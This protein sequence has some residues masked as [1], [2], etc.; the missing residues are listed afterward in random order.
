M[1]SFGQPSAGRAFAPSARQAALTDMQQRAKIEAFRKVGHA[2]LLALTVQVK[3]TCVTLMSLVAQPPSRTSPH[4]S[5]IDTLHTIVSKLPADAFTPSMINYILFPITQILRQSPP[6]SLPENCLE[7]TFRLLSHVVENWKG[8]EVGAWEQ[9]WRFTAAS[10]GISPGGEDV[11]GKG[12]QLGQETL[13][14]AVNLLAALLK[15][16]GD[17]HPSLAMLGLVSTPKSS[18]MPTLFQTITILL[19]TA[20]PSPPH[21]QL[22]LTSLRLLRAL[23]STYLTGQKTVLAAVL[24]GLVSKMAKL[25][26][27]ELKGL[28]GGIAREIAELLA[29]VIVGTL[30]DADLRGL[31]VLR[32]LVEDLGHLAEEW[33]GIAGD[34]LPPEDPPPS[35]APSA[36][37]PFPPLTASY[38][39]FTSSQLQ[40]AIPPIMSS[41]A[42]HNSYEAR[43]GAIALASALITQCSESL[44]LLVPRA[45]STLL[46]LSKDAFDPVRLDARRKLLAIIPDPELYAT[47][48]ELLSTAINSLP[49]LITSQQDE[50]LRETAQLVTALAEISTEVGTRRNPIAALL[51]PDGHVER[52][53]WALLACLEFG[54]PAGWSAADSAAKVAQR[55]WEQRLITS[56]PL[57]EAGDEPFPTMQLRH[58]E[59]EATLRAISSMLIALGAAGGETALH[60]VEHFILFARSNQKQHISKAVSSLW[61]GQKLLDGIA[62]AEDTGIEGRVGRATRK[63]AKETTKVVVAMDEDDEDLPIVQESEALIPVERSSGLNA[64]TTLLDRKPLPNSH[65]SNETR[66]LHAQAQR[67]L[68]TALSLSSLALTSRILSSSFRPLLLSSLYTLLSHLGSPQPI[69]AQYAEIALE[70][71]GYNCGYASTRN[72]IVDNVDYVINVVSQRLTYH[73]LS[74]AAPL[75][76]IAMIRLVG[77]EIVPLVHDVVDE[78]FDALDDFHGYES[79]A[80]SLLAVL[81]TLIEVMA[82]EVQDTR[83]KETRL[84]TPPDPVKDFEKFGKWYQERNQRRESEIET[85][86][87]RAPQHAWGGEWQEEEAEPPTDDSET[88][89]TRSQEVCTAILAKSIHFLTHRSPFL[90]ARVLSLVA[91]AA[92]VLA[93]GGRESDLLPIID[94]AW[95]ILLNRLEDEHPYVVTEAA[96]VIASLCENVGDFMSR[97][98][99]DWVWPR[100]KKILEAQRILDQNSALARRGVP[101]TESAYTVSHRLHVAILRTATFIAAEVP[102]NEGILWEM[103]LLFRSFLDQRVHAELQERAVGLYWKIGWRDEDALWVMI[104]ASL[105]ELEGD[106]GI[107]EWLRVDELD[108]RGNMEMIMKGF[109]LHA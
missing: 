49:R 105:G 10:I 52:W 9:L 63:M 48:L 88:P 77:D 62:S 53:S 13:Y 20:T 69:V 80:S 31:G 2:R 71:V 11:K 72:L 101:G 38:I 51:G 103:M 25:V 42:S 18:L 56:E 87:Q 83:E 79:L 45:L 99:L 100:F 3:P 76:L 24:P 64:I 102:V 54:R 4:T 28:K 8:M 82:A 75:V 14:Q 7:S 104:Q 60:S 39:A 36:P 40:S 90:R 68:L 1:D 74:S 57:R 32:P 30:G 93:A 15:P 85:I 5:L 37:D 96:E 47:L 94:K 33:D 6:S 21:H 23:I 46:L 108:V 59:S 26:H 95:P 16:R 61:V 89:P 92:P 35:P 98:V 107:Y 67:S 84:G 81:V 109:D 66:R 17:D 43:Y 27:A 78:I 22:Q 55:G 34:P 91:H 65:A 41:F 44:P 12:R 19:E 29:E 58:V 86:L 106:K 73:R 50:H 97:R 70:Q